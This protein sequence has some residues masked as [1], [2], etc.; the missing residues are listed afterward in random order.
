MDWALIKDVGFPIA[1]VV[2]FI[3]RDRER[4]KRSNI[5]EDQNAVV[6]KELNDRQFSLTER[7][8]TAVTEGNGLKREQITMQK[9][10]LDTQRE[11]KSAI[12]SLCDECKD[13]HTRMMDRK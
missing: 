12:H 4:E 13:S 8:I 10:L 11:L 1:L 6:F 9:E 5:K 3:L 7:T 2:Y